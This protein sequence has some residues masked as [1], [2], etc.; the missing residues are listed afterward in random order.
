MSQ[1]FYLSHTLRRD[2]RQVLRTLLRGSQTLLVAASQTTVWPSVGEGSE[3]GGTVRLEVG[4]A[5]ILPG[6]LSVALRWS[7]P[8]DPQGFPELSSVLEIVRAG[9]GTRLSLH[10]QLVSAPG[11]GETSSWACSWLLVA[12]L[13]RYLEEL[14]RLLERPEDLQAV[15]PGPL[16]PEGSE[17]GPR[18]SAPQTKPPVRRAPTA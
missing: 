11:A 10:G 6:R 5:R 8:Q 14:A 15:T 18:R 7:C 13:R 9:S 16:P 17:A 4:R 1:A 3:S 12:A 2:Y